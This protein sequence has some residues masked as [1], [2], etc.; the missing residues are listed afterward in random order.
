MGNRGEEGGER[1]KGELKGRGRVGE[2]KGRISESP[3]AARRKKV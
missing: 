2:R 1:S 3:N